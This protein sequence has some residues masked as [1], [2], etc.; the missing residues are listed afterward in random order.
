[1]KELKYVATMNM[2]TAAKDTNN[3]LTLGKN[4]A[5][6]AFDASVS[7]QKRNLDASVVEFNNLVDDDAPAE[8]ILKAYE[9]VGVELAKYN[10]A[11]SS[12]V[13][14]RC[15]AME[16]PVL[17]LLKLGVMKY[18][19][20]GAPKDKDNNWKK[21]ETASNSKAVSLADFADFLKKLKEEGK[22]LEKTIFPA[23]WKKSMEELRADICAKSLYDLI[24]SMN[25]GTK[26]DAR[27]EAAKKLAAGLGISYS[28]A[29]NELSKSRSNKVSK[30]LVNNAIVALLGEETVTANKIFAG[31]KH[32]A[33]LENVVIGKGRNVFSVT[34]PKTETIIKLVTEVIIAIINDLDMEVSCK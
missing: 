6:A 20:V 8:N 16:N 4:P 19:K 15:I 33:W 30:A 1:M 11:Y 32:L 34:V 12:E 27:V 25:P 17:A 18:A 24:S 9:N 2:F 21:L 14:G 7:E 5:Y 10:S 23:G 26:T 22:A 13:Y 3:N 29:N 28:D 31:T